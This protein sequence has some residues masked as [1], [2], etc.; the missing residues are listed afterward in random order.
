MIKYFLNL[1]I[2]SFKGVNEVLPTKLKKGDE[3]RVISP[4]CS[5]SIVSTENRKLAIKKIKQYGL[6]SYVLKTR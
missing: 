3:I 1:N 4:S 6:S 2:L 5:L